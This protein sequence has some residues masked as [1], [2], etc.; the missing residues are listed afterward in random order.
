MILTGKCL[1]EKIAYEIH[2]ELG[3]ITNCHCTRCRRWHAAAFRTRA[4][5]ASKDFKWIRGEK[6]IAKY[7]S[8][9]FGI[10]T[11]CSN[12]GSNLISYYENAP[13]HI[14][15]PIG[16]LDQDPGL[17]PSMHIFTANKAPWY[18]I[19]DDLPQHESWPPEGSE[20]V[21]HKK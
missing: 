21:R 4:A 1:C 10:K 5:V 8:S 14:G 6:Y 2:G 16:G 18:D 7:R 20:S 15:L 13:D 12:C 9:E 11:F 17:K 19:C 3:T